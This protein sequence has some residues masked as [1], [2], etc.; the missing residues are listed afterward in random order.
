MWFSLFLCVCV[1]L[2]YYL[3]ISVLTE[4]VYSTHLGVIFLAV[5]LF[6]VTQD[7]KTFSIKYCVEVDADTLYSHIFFLNYFIFFEMKPTIQSC[8][9]E[10]KQK[11]DTFLQKILVSVRE[12]VKHSESLPYQ[13]Y[14]FFIRIKPIN[15]IRTCFKTL[16]LD[17]GQYVINLSQY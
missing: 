4:T 13:D 3:K 12:P 5:I 16:A 15:F 17:L 10:T 9:C 6:L 14:S 8:I 11:K 1:F 2:V 7:E